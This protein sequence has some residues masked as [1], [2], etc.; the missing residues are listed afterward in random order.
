MPI[1]TIHE[2]SDS[3]AH[4]RALL[5]LDVGTKT[6][7]LAISDSAWRMAMPL[8][9][10]A[11]KKWPQDLAALVAVMKD[12]AIGGLVIGLPRNMDGS[13]GPRAQSVRALAQN[14]VARAD[15]VGDIPIAFWDER[16]STAAVER[17]LIADDMS[18]RRRDEVIDKMAAAYIL[19]GA[20]DALQASPITNRF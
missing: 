5:G 16:L 1:F 6:I 2:L 14:L 18:R 12:R 13:E 10:I 15:V 19:Q 7:G 8:H 3:S 4:G 17:A 9:T 20:L 11:R